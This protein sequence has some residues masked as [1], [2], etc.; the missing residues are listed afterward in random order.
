MTSFLN[1]L[2]PVV[3]GGVDV[4]PGDPS[5][6]FGSP[7]CTI[8][9]PVRAKLGNDLP[10]VAILS[11]SWLGAVMALAASPSE[12]II[13]LSVAIN[14]PAAQFLHLRTPCL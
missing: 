9:D 4:V 6:D 11:A 1:L 10:G 3:I 7:S 2:T 13:F 5:D 8:P 12:A 14:R